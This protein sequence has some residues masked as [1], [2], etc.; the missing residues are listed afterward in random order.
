MPS[1][2]VPNCQLPVAVVK[3]LFHCTMATWRGTGEATEAAEAE[4]AER[5]EGG[6]VKCVEVR[7]A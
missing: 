5:L 1:G 4:E 6:H 7:V 2:R 3:T